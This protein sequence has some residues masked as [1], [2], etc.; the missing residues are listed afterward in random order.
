M[1]PTLK[2]L[3]AHVGV[4]LTTASNAYNRPGKLSPALRE[5][6]LEAATELGYA[7]P[8]PVARRL[9]RGR[10]GLVGALLPEPLGY[11]FRDPGAVAFLSGLA[12]ALQVADLGLTLLPVL[13]DD[14]APG[15]VA[16]AAVDALAL[17][18]VRDDH[19][20]LEVV[21]RRGLPV[22]ASG[23]PARAG[24]PLVAADDRALAREAAAHLLGLGHRRIGVVAFRTGDR[25]GSDGYR[26]ARLRLAGFSDAL[27][28]AGLDPSA[29]P[30][31]LGTRNTRTEGA[32]AASGIL[33]G[34][35]PERPTALLCTSDEL[36]LGARDAAGAL[37]LAVPADLSLVGFDD[38]GPA[39]DSGLTTV[40]QDLA[41]Q[42]VAVGEALLAALAGQPARDQRWPGRLVVRSSTAP[43]P[44]VG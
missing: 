19:P 31:A 24:I 12:E 28:A 1:A 29:A 34:A 16:D 10:T 43:P 41:G 2:D 11:A 32:R 40:A 6:I 44:G 26:V 36:A 14:A 15:A 22:V 4:S 7:G 37:G 39:A 8:D 38:A 33:D 5:R 23:G 3:A 17:F 20:L 9:R 30:R 35:G 21:L 13:D 25:A 27:A 18:S 42:G